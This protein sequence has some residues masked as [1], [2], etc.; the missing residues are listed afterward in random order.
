MSSLSN[1]ESHSS[2][3]IDNKYLAINILMTSYI[4]ME[5]YVP[6]ILMNGCHWSK[7]Q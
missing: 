1:I 2:I 4:Q 3:K 6:T 7:N 5:S